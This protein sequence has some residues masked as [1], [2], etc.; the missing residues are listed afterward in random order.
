MTQ[1]TTFASDLRMAPG[2]WPKVFWA[3]EDTDDSANLQAGRWERVS[4]KCD[5]EGETVYVRY[6]HTSGETVLVYND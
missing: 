1:T 5:A 3:F 2:S 6:R 4:R